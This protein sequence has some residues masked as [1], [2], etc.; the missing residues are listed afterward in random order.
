MEL[1]ERL[2]QCLEEAVA[3]QEA[4]RE[5]RLTVRSRK[6]YENEVLCCKR[7]DLKKEKK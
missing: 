4:A 3:R 1:K 7:Q 6:G 2:A 5:A